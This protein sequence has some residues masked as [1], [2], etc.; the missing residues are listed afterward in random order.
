VW[1]GEGRKEE[2]EEEARPEA[3]AGGRN[4]V[5]KSKTAYPKAQRSQR[6]VPLAEDDLREGPSE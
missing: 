1:G 6:G 3:R 4:C 5:V 2:A